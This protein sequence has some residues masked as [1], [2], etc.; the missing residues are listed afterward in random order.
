MTEESS[1]NPPPTH[2]RISPI[3]SSSNGMPSLEETD[4]ATLR[5]ANHVV[6]LNTMAIDPSG[7]RDSTAPFVTACS[8]QVVASST[9]GRPKG[10]LLNCFVVP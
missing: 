6:P 2:P 1:N 3:S 8:S 10:Q 9:S 4:G 5:V 7:R